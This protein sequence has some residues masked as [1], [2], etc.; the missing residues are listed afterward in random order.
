M[1]ATATGPG[2]FRSLGFKNPSGYW[3]LR[4]STYSHTGTGVWAAPGRFHVWSV[5]VPVCTSDVA[6]RKKGQPNDDR[7][8]SSVAS[9][10]GIEPTPA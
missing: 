5:C 2:I 4:R 8:A 3:L 1:W 6:W 10:V 7:A 9:T